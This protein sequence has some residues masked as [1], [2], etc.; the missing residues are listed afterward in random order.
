M[1]NFTNLR[2]F[3]VLAFALLTATLPAQCI[4]FNGDMEI[5]ND[6]VNNFPAG[7]Y[8]YTDGVIT[9]SI[10]SPAPDGSNTAVQ[11][12]QSGGNFAG[13]ALGVNNLVA[14]MEYTFSAD[15]E[16]TAGTGAP[17]I[18]I[19][20]RDA[21]GTGLGQ[22]FWVFSASTSLGDGVQRLTVTAIAPAGTDQAQ[23]AL[24]W[25]DATLITDNFCVE[26][27]GGNTFDCPGN[28]VGNGSLDN[29]T[30]GWFT[31]AGA[32]IAG[33]ADAYAGAMA[34]SWDAN[35]QAAFVITDGI[36]PGN[37]ISFSAFIK[38][39]AG[40]LV[41]GFRNN[42]NGSEIYGGTG[43]TTNGGADYE[44]VINETS[45]IPEGTDEI[46]LFA[47]GDGGVAGLV[48][49]VCVTDLGPDPGFTF[50]IE[51]AAFTG[52][53][54]DKYNSFSWTTVTEENTNMF[55]LERSPDGRTAW[56]IVAQEAAAGNSRTDISYATR[57]EAPLSNGYYRL[58]SVDFDGSEQLS[59]VVNI[60]RQDANSV[61]VYPNPFAD[62]L[63]VQTSLERAG[64]YQLT[65][66]TGRII[67]NG[68]VE[69]GSQ[70]LI[71]PTATLPAGHYFLRVGERT[72]KVIK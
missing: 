6:P 23:M 31:F 68:A 29:D 45:T 50:P 36:V 51:L 22:G 49:N 9:T 53:A 20:W 35:S 48:D 5:A 34:G 25:T 32:G 15:V 58:R 70:K 59:D 24:N 66:V 19:D 37:R 54:A 55:H 41:F 14:G 13:F 62:V 33:S 38:S 72:L 44:Q 18:F 65:D 28:L 39:T 27:A 43:F 42:D 46:I 2:S 69:E 3:L 30:G 61:F 12:V 10:V 40:Q 71:I 4:N 21:G 7:Y 63:T 64:S 52:R 56:Q 57:D 60:V 1:Q 26:L 47:Q 8:D 67:R 17:N 11:V 16:V